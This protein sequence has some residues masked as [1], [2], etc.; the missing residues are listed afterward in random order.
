[1]LRRRLRGGHQV[2]RGV[3]DAP[4]RRRLDR[5]RLRRP[6]RLAGHVARRHRPL[7]DAVDRLAGLAVQDVEVAGLG[8]HPEGRDRTVLARNVEQGRRRRRIGVPQVVV[9]RLEVPDVL[10]GLGPDRDDRVAVEVRARPVA[11]VVARNRRRQRQVDEAALGVRGEEERPRVGA[12]PSPPTV[13]GPGLVPD[14]ARLGHRIEL[15]QLRAAARVVGAG[16]ADAPDGAGRRVG[17]DDHDVP[18]HERHRVVGHAQVHRAGVPET[19]RGFPA[20]G[21]QGVQAQT[22]GEQDARL[23]PVVAR[24][25]GDAAARR[26]AARQRM[27]PDLLARLRP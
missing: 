19:G 17:A 1:M 14:V 10:A 11:A 8:G 21:V 5:E 4:H 13:A 7:L 25:P 24:P 26:R 15:P 12:Q 27:A 16:V 23:V 22:G 9:N 20:G 18:V 3:A 2:V 6:G